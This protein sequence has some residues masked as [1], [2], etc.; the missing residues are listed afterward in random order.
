MIMALYRLIAFMVWFGVMFALC[1]I[2]VAVALALIVGAVLMGL[3]MPSRTVRGQLRSV[4]VNCGDLATE[5]DALRPSWG[6]GP[7]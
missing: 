2:V 1:T 7:I 4:V 6:R 3:T 5:I